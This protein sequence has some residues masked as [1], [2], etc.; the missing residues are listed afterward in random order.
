MEIRK[1]WKLFAVPFLFA[2][3]LTATAPAV[4]PVADPV[5]AV[6][7]DGAASGGELSAQS[8]PDQVPFVMFFYHFIWDG[9]FATFGRDFYA[10]FASLTCQAK[11]AIADWP[12]NCPTP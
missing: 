4:A 6:L 11:N 1:R 12:C 10:W 2:V 8:Q 9:N 5:L 3:G 7:T